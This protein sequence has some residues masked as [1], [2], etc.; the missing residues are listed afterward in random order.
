M[1]RL[2]IADDERMEREALADIVMRRFEH[3]VTVEMAE[4]GRK[5]ADTAVLWEADLILMDIEMP[6]MNGLD[7]ARAVLEQRPE[8][9]VIFITAY[10]LFQYA[11]EAVHLGACDYLLKPVDPDEKDHCLR[12]ML[13]FL[14][15]SAREKEAFEERYGV[16]IMNTYGSTESVG[17]V[18]T[19]PPTGER[20][21]P[22][23]G[24]V[25][26]GYE[27][28]I[29]D[30]EGNELPAGEVGEICVKGVPG[31]SIM[32]GYLGNEAATAEALSGDGWLRMGD[33][34]YYDENGWFFFFDRKS[35]MIKRS[36]ENISTTEIEGILEEHPD[37]KE[38]AVIGVPD[39]IRDQAVKAFVLPED[40][41]TIGADEVIAYCEGN[42]AA[43]KVPSIVEIVEDFPRTCSMKI[44]KKL[45]K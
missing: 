6:G 10:S 25:G 34:G 41:A 15:V 20:N 45:L 39:P 43:F 31:R 26:L 27:A 35:N 13:Y 23:I 11:H 29:V 38:A 32:L 33:K 24:R 37:I 28:K 2:L 8:C 18:L 3:E 36:G 21:W 19:D 30:E 1:I 9:K 22:S 44:E 4:N 40:G 5:A 42:M 14:P 7:A 12:D 16:R 17:W